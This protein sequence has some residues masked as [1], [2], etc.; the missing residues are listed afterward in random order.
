MGQDYSFL[1][2]NKHA[3]KDIAASMESVAEALDKDLDNKKREDF[4][5]L[6]PAHTNILSKN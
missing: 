2:K 1:D 5:E 4:H 3:K 6:L